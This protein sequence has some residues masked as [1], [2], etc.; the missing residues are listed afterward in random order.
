M[1]VLTFTAAGS[2]WALPVAQV[3]EVFEKAR[4]ERLAMV[5]PAV[6]GVLDLRGQPV[7][8]IDLSAMA[9]H[10]GGGGPRNA[11]VARHGDGVVALLVDRIDTVLNA[12]TSPRAAEETRAWVAANIAGTALIDVEGL[13]A[14][15][16]VATEEDPA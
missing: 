5:S 6:A 16:A 12:D 4:V 9:G 8:A 11:V 7:A 1:R 2:H 3:Q 15:P 13:L 14:D 10:G